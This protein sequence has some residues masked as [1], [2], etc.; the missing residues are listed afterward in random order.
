MAS[1]LRRRKPQ[2]AGGIRPSPLRRFRAEWLTAVAL[3]AGW[4]ALT[5]AVAVFLTPSV[6]WTVSGGLLAISLGG[7]RLLFVVAW[8]GLY[9]LSRD[10]RDG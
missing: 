4:A 3:F 2:V 1:A 8:H 7:W 9:D 10:G 5:A 6:V